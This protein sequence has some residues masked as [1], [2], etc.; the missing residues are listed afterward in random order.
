MR[1]NGLKNGF[2]VLLIYI[3]NIFT[4]YIN[5]YIFFNSMNAF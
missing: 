3:L 5:T 2:K 4:I 1:I